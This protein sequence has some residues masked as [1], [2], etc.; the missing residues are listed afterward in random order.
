MKPGFQVLCCICKLQINGIARY[1]VSG[2][3]TSINLNML[4]NRSIHIKLLTQIY[5]LS[6]ESQKGVIA[7]QRCSI[8]NQKGAIAVQS[9]WQ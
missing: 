8:E 2:E 3:E 7:A 6:V 5:I 1:Y 4:V 9:Q